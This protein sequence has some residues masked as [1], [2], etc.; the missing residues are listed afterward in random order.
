MTDHTDA[1]AD[2]CPWQIPPIS[3]GRNENS[4]TR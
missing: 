3:L 4:S 2:A 1:L